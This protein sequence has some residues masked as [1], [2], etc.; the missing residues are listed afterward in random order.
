[1]HSMN[2]LYGQSMGDVTPLH[3]GRMYERALKVRLSKELAKLK[4]DEQLDKIFLDAIQTEI[5]RL[6]A[7]D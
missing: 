7:Y 4:T 2:L 5:A 1:M 3:F 6:E